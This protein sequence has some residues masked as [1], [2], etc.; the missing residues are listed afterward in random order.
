MKRDERKVHSSPTSLWKSRSGVT[1]LGSVEKDTAKPLN[2]QDTL[3]LL[4]STSL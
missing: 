4:I 2:D 1:T 3:G